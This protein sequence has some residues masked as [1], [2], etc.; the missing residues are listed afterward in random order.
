MNKN[1]S[2]Q[3]H[4]RTGDAFLTRIILFCSDM[5]LEVSKHNSQSIRS[6]NV[7]SKFHLLRLDLD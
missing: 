2:T 3:N 1:T 7:M 5:G 6:C 4:K